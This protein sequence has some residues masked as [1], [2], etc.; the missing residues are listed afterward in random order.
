MTLS[1]IKDKYATSQKGQEITN[2]QM[3]IKSSVE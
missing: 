3:T 2:H 1:F